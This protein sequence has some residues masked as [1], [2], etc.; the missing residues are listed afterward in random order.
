MAAL[1][2]T[3]DE[4]R[5]LLDMETAIEVVEQ[6]FVAL[7]EGTAENV[8]RARAFAPGPFFLHTMSATADYLGVSG[9]KNYSSRPGHV[10]FL[11][12]LY[13][14]ETGK[15]IALIEA[16]YLGQLRTGAA[17]G[18]ATDYMA[19]PDS[20]VVG[21][22]GTGKQARTQLKAVCE[23]RKIDY[24]EVYSRND[25]NRRRF[26]DEMSELC[27]TEVEPV[28]APDTAA[29]EKD[30][31]ITATSSSAPV[32]DGRV[33][34]EGTHLNVVGS[35]FLQKAE[36]DVTTVRRADV[37]AC[38]SIAQCQLE[39]GDFSA[40][41]TEHAIDW[42]LMHELSAIVTG[43]NTGRPQKDSVTLFK[44]TGLAI[45]DVALAAKLVDLATKERIGKPLPF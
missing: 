22:F 27:N 43:R 5:D 21:V 12:G 8:P 29:T 28:H 34:D 45:E 23:T 24:V 18:V 25:E 16:D 41:L 6:A 35:N 30:I 44:S 39:A 31:V 40:A 9:W 15:L 26:A 3:E 7:A 42:P 37:I 20:K 36:I 13:S 11:V 2:I 1:F 33:L 10:E 38:D 19:R 17:S 32:F 4:V 14:I